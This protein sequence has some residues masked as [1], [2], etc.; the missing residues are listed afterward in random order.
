MKKKE[1]R[2][3][4]IRQILLEEGRVSVKEL[5]KR[6]EVT[7]E[8]LRIDLN[9]LEAKQLVHRQHGYAIGGAVGSELPVDVRGQEN[10]EDKKRIAYRAMQEI[11]DGQVV[12]LD[13]G[14]TIILGLPVL[15]F[16]KDITIVTNSVALAYQA[17]L[18]QLNVVMAGGPVSNVGQRTYGHFVTDILD[19]ITFDVAIMGTDGLKNAKGFTTMAMDEVSIKRHIIAQSQKLI[20]VA[21]ASKFDRKAS[22][23]YCSFKEFDMLVTNPLNQSQLEQVTDIKR[24]IEV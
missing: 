16:K 13:S 7:P 20:T 18:L 19:H 4:E 9:E 21:D 15:S 1:V 8:T 22:Y 10:A 12:F 14:S 3:K 6:L 11:K 2:Q 17:S 24:V 5:A 23:T